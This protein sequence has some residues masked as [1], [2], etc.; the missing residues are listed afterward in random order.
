MNLWIK[1]MIDSYRFSIEYKNLLLMGT[2]IFK[3][4]ISAEN[5]IY[6]EYGILGLDI[7]LKANKDLDLC[8]CVAHVDSSFLIDEEINDNIYDLSID[9]IV[10]ESDKCNYLINNTVGLTELIPVEFKC[11]VDNTFVIQYTHN[12]YINSSPFESLYSLL[13]TKNTHERYSMLLELPLYGDDKSYEIIGDLINKDIFSQLSFSI[14]Y[15]YREGY[16][17]YIKTSI[18]KLNSINYNLV[19]NKAICLNLRELC[20]NSRDDET[21]KMNYELFN[22]L[23]ELKNQGYE[24]YYKS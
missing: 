18:E 15:Q 13:I 10:V 12:N 4:Y 21:D 5:T 24:I 23:M 3:F 6:S 19:E 8:S 2:E 14:K 22:Y 11:K 7:T 16:L 9:K 17:D 1:A 20:N